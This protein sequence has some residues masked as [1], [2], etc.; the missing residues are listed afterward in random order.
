MTD[1]LKG[2]TPRCSGFNMTPGHNCG[3]RTSTT[4]AVLCD[5]CA[6]E[7][8]CCDFKEEF[9][10]Q[11]QTF[12]IAFN[13]RGVLPPTEKWYM[14]WVFHEEYEPNLYKNVRTFVCLSCADRKAVREFGVPHYD[15]DDE[16]VVVPLVACCTQTKTCKLAEAFWGKDNG[17]TLR[18]LMDYIHDRKPEPIGRSS[19]PEKR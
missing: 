12:F 6:C 18:R 1:Y 5:R 2:L 13:V 7:K 10:K 17:L 15:N 14:E 16:G 8:N 3:R 19:R 11:Y 4:E 9:A